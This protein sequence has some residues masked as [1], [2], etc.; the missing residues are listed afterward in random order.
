MYTY[1]FTYIQMQ[2][3]VTIQVSLLHI[4]DICT[5][6]NVAAASGYIMG[7]IIDNGIY[8]PLCTYSY[9]R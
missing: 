8:F 7:Y 6:F 2:L 4:Y 9:R 1:V 3:E 5:H